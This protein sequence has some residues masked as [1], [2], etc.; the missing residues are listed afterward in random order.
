V[1]GRILAGLLPR[2]GAR[3]L[4]AFC[5]LRAVLLPLLLCCNVV[6]PRRWRVRRS[7]GGSD[8][9]PMVLIALLALSNG[10]AASV[11][12]ATGP[13]CVPPPRRGAVASTLVA[14][15]LSGV[16]LGSLLSMLLSASLQGGVL[17]Q[18]PPPM[19]PMPYM[20]V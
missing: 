14:Y 5:V 2:A 20:R 3:S 16:V 19:P 15:L 7:L 8:S 6:P 18:S 4:L 9:A 12:F 17:P 13:A 10:Y 11:A 1:V